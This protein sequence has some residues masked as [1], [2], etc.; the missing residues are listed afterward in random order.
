MLP[1][2]TALPGDLPHR[3]EL[4]KESEEA[5]VE[6]GQSQRSDEQTAL[7][8]GEGRHLSISINILAVGDK[9]MFWVVIR[10]LIDIHHISRLYDLKIPTSFAKKWVRR[11]LH[12]PVWCQHLAI[13]QGGAQERG[14][15][16]PH[17]RSLWSLTCAN[18]CKSLEWFNISVRRELFHQG[19]HFPVTA[20]F[21]CSSTTNL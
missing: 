8:R 19:C 16:L 7:Q 14:N 21:W 4:C 5:S 11:N 13:S 9:P 18:Y 12:K 17:L 15:F 1:K 6:V 3:G 10:R 20:V 2:R